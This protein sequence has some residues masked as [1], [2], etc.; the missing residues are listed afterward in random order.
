[1]CSKI[2]LKAKKKKMQKIYIYILAKEIVNDLCVLSGHNS[3]TRALRSRVQ[4]LT[5]KGTVNK[6]FERR[7][8]FKNISLLPNKSKYKIK[9]DLDLLEINYFSSYVLSMSKSH[10][11]EGKKMLTYKF[12]DNFF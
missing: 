1:M 2:L 9:F 7:E 8:V 5:V 12:F 10:C 3:R 4:R 11:H 6:L